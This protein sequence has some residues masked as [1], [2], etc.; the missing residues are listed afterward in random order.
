MFALW[1]MHVAVAGTTAGGS[2]PG[3]TLLRGVLK[4]CHPGRTPLGVHDHTQPAARGPHWG[5]LGGA[6]Q[7]RSWGNV[8]HGH[9]SGG[10]GLCY[11]CVRIARRQAAACSSSS[12]KWDLELGCECACLVCTH[13]CRYGTIV[14]AQ[15]GRLYVIYNRNSN[16]VTT[17]PGSTKLIR[18]D[19]LGFFAMR[20]SD[21]GGCDTPPPTHTHSQTRTPCFLGRVVFRLQ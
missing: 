12:C 4:G 16:N 15:S 9:S 14:Q 11:Q 7:R 10:S 21:D 19:E 20:W 3:P 8:D 17:L 6:V 1:L 5:A 13:A 2:I 18:N